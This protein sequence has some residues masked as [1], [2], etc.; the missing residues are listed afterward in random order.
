[1]SEL[2]EVVD[3]TP[4]RFGGKAEQLADRLPSLEGRTIGLLWNSK[5]N[6]DVALRRA[7]EM[8]A[9]RV[10]GVDV[11]FFNGNTPSDPAVV[12]QAARECDAV[13]GC[14]ADCGA[15]SSWIA[16]DCAQLERRGIPTVII[17]SAGFE[18]D[19]EASAEAFAV[20]GL[21]YVV[22][23]KVYNNL[24]AEESVTQ[25]EPVVD[26]IIKL[27]TSPGEASR[28]SETDEHGAERP[29]QALSYEGPTWPAA[30]DAFN[31]EF[32]D[33]EWGDGYPLIPPTRDKVDAILKEIDASEDEILCLVPPGNGEGTALA[34]AANAAMAGCQPREVPVVLAVL[35]ALSEM[36]ETRAGDT[37]SV[38][39][40]TSAHAPLIVVN[41]PAAKELGINGGRS[42]L[43]PGKQNEVN[44]RIGRAI[45][46]CLRNL[47]RWVLGVMDL[48]TLGT[49]RKHISVIAENEAESPWEP[50]HV[51]QGFRPEDST[52]TVF[53]T[54]GEWDIPIQGHQ[55]AQQLAAAIASLSAGNNDGYFG[56]LFSGASAEEK[57]RS[58]LGRLMLIQPPHAIP[59][60]EGGFSKHGLQKYFYFQGQEPIQRLIEPFKKQYADGK[61]KPEWQWAFELTP[62]EAAVR[63]LPVLE[64]PEAYHIVVAGSV[65]AKDLLFPT[66]SIPYTVLL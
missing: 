21:Q 33:R 55:N 27:L 16:Y 29:A 2:L 9:E 45:G 4:R 53:F 10:P 37:R 38:L 57:R 24:E 49:T 47:G 30:A 11:R 63:T 40:S 23:P 1:M 26:G 7:G 56:S 61:V 48:D 43:G 28:A 62:Q 54:M 20:P 36:N 14:T 44:L 39:S 18:H 12:D 6:G 32:L 5:A 25:T 41:G 58:G 46:L 15:C 34:I 8:I 59:L 35:R 42:C 17:V 3:P 31:R 66:R 51:S 60:S 52:V 19:V 50:L 64:S 22:V 65:R 13:I